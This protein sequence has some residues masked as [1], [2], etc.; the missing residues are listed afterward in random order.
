ML[1]DE[2]LV[3]VYVFFFFF[4][5]WVGVTLI[6]KMQ[7]KKPQVFVKAIHNRIVHSV[8]VMNVDIVYEASW[9]L[10]SADAGTR[11]CKSSHIRALTRTV[12]CQLGKLE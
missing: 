7:L 1:S 12:L 2:N 4:F 6:T 11:S 9:Q 3:T 8:Y 10:L 5:F